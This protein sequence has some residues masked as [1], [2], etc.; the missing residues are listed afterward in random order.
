MCSFTLPDIFVR[1]SNLR[2]YTI[3]R[4]DIRIF[5]VWF[6]FSTNSGISLYIFEFNIF[7]LYIFESKR[8]VMEENLSQVL[9]YGLMCQYCQFNVS[10]KMNDSF[11]LS[12]CVKNE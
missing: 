8:R 9:S 7:S 3:R 5:L 12:N 10:G 2:F 6:M 11:S 4:N 1:G